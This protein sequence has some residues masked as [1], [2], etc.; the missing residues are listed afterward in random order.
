MKLG[1]LFWIKKLKLKRGEDECDDTLK[2]IKRAK[3]KYDIE[4]SFIEA[5]SLWEIFSSVQYAGWLIYSDELFDDF[6]DYF[7]LI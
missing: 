6:I 4:L 1:D 3:E 5:Y 2:I 7:E